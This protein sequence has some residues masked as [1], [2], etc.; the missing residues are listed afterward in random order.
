MNVRKILED[1]RKKY[2]VDWSLI[3][4][5]YALSWMLYGI[6]NV[7]KL[8]E[9]LIFKGGTCLKKSYFGDY[10]FSQDLD[11]SVQGQYPMQDEL[12]M[13]I[14]QASSIAS[15]Q[16]QSIKHNITFNVIRYTEKKEHPENQEAFVIAVRY[17]WHKEPLTKIMVEITVTENIYFP[18]QTRNIIHLYEDRLECALKT[19]SLEEIVCEKIAALLSFSKKLHERGWGRSR[20]RDYYDLWRILGSHMA[21][22]NKESILS[23]IQKKCSRK[24]I[25]FK[26][27]NDLFDEKL[28]ADFDRSWNL[29]VEPLVPNCPKKE[30]VLTE[31]QI[32]LP[33][34]L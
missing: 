11:F 32:F 8:Q 26:S 16:L 25:E 28:M 4:Q 19:Y 23:V 14:K 31:L 5:D 22:L 2:P 33:E 15:H 18:I 6:S 1:H 12:E 13:L 27:V 29:W 21:S 7:P 34:V 10:R 3:E 30:I 9:H 24:S 20:A 17:P